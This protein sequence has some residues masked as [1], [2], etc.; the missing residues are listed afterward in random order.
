MTE[1]T[2]RYTRVA[3]RFTD[4]VREVPADS[5][6]NASPCEG[7]T[8]RDIVRHLVE[9]IPGYFGDHGVEFGAIASVDDDPVAAWATV[10]GVLSAALADATQATRII[11]GPFGPQSL[12]ETVDMIVVG[13]V[14]IHTWDL[15]RATELDES[16]DADQVQRMLASMGSIPDEVL[17]SGGMFGP[18]IDV[19]DDTDDQTKLLAFVGRRA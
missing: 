4:R 19:A 1:I 3:G 7:W 14:C 9:W 6:D 8:A 2:E 15:A 11:E 16:L 10:D 12:A 13:D 5:W 17:R 18:R